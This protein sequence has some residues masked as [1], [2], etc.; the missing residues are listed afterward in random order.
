MSI[1]LK[2]FSFLF[3]ALMLSMGALAACGGSSSTGGTSSSNGP[4]T[5]TVA[6][7]QFGPPPYHD[8]DWWTQVKQQV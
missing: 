8:G 7:Q 3:F 6:Y 2:H 1:R 4:V 5:I